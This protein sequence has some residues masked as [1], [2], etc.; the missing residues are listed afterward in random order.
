VIGAK[1]FS[2]QYIL[3]ELMADRLEGEGASVQRKINLGSAVAYRAL[4]PARSTPMSTIPA[5]CGPTS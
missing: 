2:E 5:P 4:A 3:A 1:N